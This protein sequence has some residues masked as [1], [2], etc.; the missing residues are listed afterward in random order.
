MLLRTIT[1]VALSLF[2]VSTSF[3]SSA[4]ELKQPTVG[5]SVLTTKIGTHEIIEGI[6]ITSDATILAENDE[7]VQI[8]RTYLNT[9]NIAYIEEILHDEVTLYTLNFKNVGQAPLKILLA[10][11][12]NHKISLSPLYQILQDFSF[13]LEPNERLEVRFLANGKPLAGNSLVSVATY[14]IP[15]GVK[16]NYKTQTSPKWQFHSMGGMALWLPDF[17]SQ[18]LTLSSKRD[19]F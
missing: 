4:R 17:F 2:V 9:Q 15:S 1:A 13:S 14:K 3:A 11:N 7:R 19:S 18:T 16:E 10:E 12:T 6:K 8:F 5:G